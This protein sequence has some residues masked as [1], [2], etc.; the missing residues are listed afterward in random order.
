[1]KTLVMMVGLPRSGK[2]TICREV[3][4]NNPIV[5]PDAIRIALHGQ[6][7]IPTAEQIVWTIAKYMVAALFEA[8]HD[9]VV[10]D[11][12]NTTKQRRDQWKDRRWKRVFHTV[13]ASKELCIQRALDNNDIAL[14]DVIEKMHASYEEA[15]V[16]ELSSWE[17]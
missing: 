16:D 17:H 10:L 6:A 1:M 2:S 11:D 15:T 13:N 4:N 3:F 9:V 7:F 5:S 8:G 14:A 12:T